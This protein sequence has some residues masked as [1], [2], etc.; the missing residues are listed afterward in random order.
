MLNK[1]KLSVGFSVVS[2][3]KMSSYFFFV[4][5]R[6]FIVIKS[7][8]SVNRSTYKIKGKTLFLKIRIKENRYIRFN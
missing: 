6:Y 8:Y 3:A 7:L 4:L 5:S 2:N 1:S